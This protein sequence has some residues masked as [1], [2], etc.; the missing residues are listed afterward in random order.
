MGHSEGRPWGPCS[1][2]SLSVHAQGTLHPVGRHWAPD[3][4]CGPTSAR[5]GSGTQGA[6]PG[7]LWH[8]AAVRLCPGDPAPSGPPLGPEAPCGKEWWARQGKEPPIKAGWAEP[9]T[10]ARSQCSVKHPEHH[11]GAHATRVN[12]EVHATRNQQG[13]C[14]R[15]THGVGEH[16]WWTAGTTRGGAGHLGLTHTETQRGRLWTA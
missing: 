7:P 12:H 9:R 10:I 5:R 4:F 8:S 14:T 15:A 3:V 6:N 16:M 2:T 1:A 13:T 11:A